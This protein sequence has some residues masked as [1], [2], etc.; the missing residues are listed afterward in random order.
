[1]LEVFVGLFEFFAH[2]VV[3]PASYLKWCKGV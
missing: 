1:M 3:E 2:V